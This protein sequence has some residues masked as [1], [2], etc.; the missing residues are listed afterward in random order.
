[1]YSF[2]LAAIVAI[3]SAQDAAVSADTA[4]YNETVPEPEPTLAEKL[5]ELNEDGQFQLVWPK[6]P[7]ITFTD[8]D[9]A[10]IKAWF[11]GK[12]DEATALDMEFLEAYK[13]YESAVHAPYNDFLTEVEDLTV[14]GI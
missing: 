6:N 13:T 9:D 11:E 5:F 3:A 12:M 14:R 8:A 1:M 7:A 10:A 2:A 4:Y